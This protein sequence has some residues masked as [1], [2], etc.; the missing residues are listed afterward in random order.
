MYHEHPIKMLKYSAKN[1]WLL[2]FP[3]MRGIYTYHFDKDWFYS[4]VK[5]AWFDIA[6]LGAILVFGFVR[7]FFSRIDF[8]SEEIIH[9][10][11]VFVRVNTYIPYKNISSTTV[12]QPFYLAPFKA[13]RFRCDTRAGIFKTVDMKLIVGKKAFEAI[14]LHMPDINEK[15]KIEGLPQ[16][17]MLSVLLFSIFFSSGFSGTIYVATFFF[18][19]GDIAYNIISRSLNLIT[20][21]TA[22]ISEKLVLKIPTAALFIGVFFIISWFLSFLVN[23]FRY[24]KFVIECDKKYMKIGYGIL[25]RKEYRIKTSH[26]NYTDLRQ[27]LIMKLFGAVAVNINCPGYGSSKNRLPVLLPVKFE[28]NLSKDLNAIGIYSG[29][30]NDYSAQPAGIGSY[31]LIPLLVTSLIIPSHDWIA[32][33]YPRFEELSFFIAV[34]L[35]IPAVWFVIVKFVALLTSGVALYEDKIM[36]RCSAWTR[37][38]TVVSE[39]EKVIKIELEQNLLQAMN[40]RCAMSIWF[41]G[42]EHKRFRIKAMK[43]SEVQKI[44][45]K[46]GYDLGSKVSA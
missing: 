23:L 8:T 2:V 9:R 32:R 26:I 35:E 14:M 36:V 11:G 37:F 4:W 17:N 13:L 18:K 43:A 39:K 7:W 6:V 25:N 15:K 46:L 3:L 44:A 21:E 16:I 34:M 38:H 40:G 5:G 12:E 10:D 1:I 33:L 41:E 27:N 19:G 29:I 45:Q 30:K 42:E 24:G 28:K 31:L 22:K 20:A